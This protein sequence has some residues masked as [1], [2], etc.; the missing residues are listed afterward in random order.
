MSYI[1]HRKAV[2]VDVDQNGRTTARVASSTNTIWI[3]IVAAIL[4]TFILKYNTLVTNT[5]EKT[6]T[7]IA[8]R[9]RVIAPVGASPTI[10]YCRTVATTAVGEVPEKRILFAVVLI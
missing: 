8:R 5:S 9:R 2:A 4:H 7:R 6:Q 1:S 3:V 10:A